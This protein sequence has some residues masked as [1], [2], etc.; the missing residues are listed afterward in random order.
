MGLSIFEGLGRLS[1]NPLRMVF[2]VLE[3]IMP[4]KTYKGLRYWTPTGYWRF[5]IGSKGDSRGS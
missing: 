2:D 5:P 4:V 1:L 3:E